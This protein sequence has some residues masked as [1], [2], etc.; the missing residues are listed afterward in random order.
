MVSAQQS[1]EKRRKNRIA[2]LS[3]FD[4][5]HAIVITLVVVSLMLAFVVRTVGVY[6]DSMEPTLNH[7][8]RLLLTSYSTDYAKGDI[9]VVDRYT[10]EPLIKRVI[11]VAGDTVFIS[12][13]Y[14][15]YVNGV[16]QIEPYIQGYTVHRDLKEPV[17]VPEGHVF[18]LGDNRT[19]S[20]DSRMKVIGMVSEKDIVGRVVGRIWPLSEIGGVYDNIK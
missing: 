16:P 11:A 15:L 13:G 9:V 4:L 17:T 5:V 12:D 18:V 7:G 10:E 14:L 3:A 1:Q 8:D 2:L 19:V 6:G 20:K